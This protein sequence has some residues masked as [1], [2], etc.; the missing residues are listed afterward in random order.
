MI[1]YGFDFSVNPAISK[2]GV[3]LFNQTACRFDFNF[4]DRVITFSNA[5]PSNLGSP[6]QDALTTSETIVATIYLTYTV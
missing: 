6:S 5:T 2:R 1:S 3:S 4:V